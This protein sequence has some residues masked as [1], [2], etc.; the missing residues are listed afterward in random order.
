MR[1]RKSHAFDEDARGKLEKTLIRIKN[2]GNIKNMQLTAAVWMSLYEP[3]PTLTSHSLSHSF[4]SLPTYVYLPMST[5]LC[6]ITYVYLPLSVTS[7]SLCHSSHLPLSVT[8]LI[9]LPLAPLTPYPLYLPMSRNL[10]TYQP[11]P[12]YFCIIVTDPRASI[13]LVYLHC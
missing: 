8:P 9:S 4:I 10:P 2:C 13:S 1:Q 11:I 7:P 6:L 12:T 5:Y 3:F